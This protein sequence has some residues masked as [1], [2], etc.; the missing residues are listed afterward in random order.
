MNNLTFSSFLLLEFSDIRNLQILYFFIFLALYMITLIGN[1]LIIAAIAI[2]YHLHTPM[3]FFLMNLAMMDLGIVSVTIPKLMT[4]YLMNSRS[5][6]FFGCVAQVFFYLFFGTCDF[7]LLIVMAHD[8]HVAICKPLQYERIMHRGACIWLAAATWITS[9]LNAMMQTGT[10]FATTFCSN[11]IKQFFCE[12]PQ[13]LKLS[14]CKCYFAEFWVL[15]IMG[16]ITIISFMYI[17]LTYMKI[18]AAVLRI[19]SVNG[20]KKALSTCLPHLVVISVF[21]FSGLFVYGRIYIEDSCSPNIIFS[22]L[23]TIIPPMLN[24]FIYSMRNKEIKAALKKWLHDGFLSR[25]L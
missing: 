7:A 12:I 5:I 4:N 22:V 16:I 10:T 2:D 17:I 15:V 23:Y 11:N 9:L 1:L 20:Q 25:F 18:F 14:C 8:R 21:M 19:P 6:S 3:Y 24:P 13:L